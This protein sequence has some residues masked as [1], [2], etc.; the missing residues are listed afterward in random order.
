MKT[1]R[2]IF[3]V[4]GCGALARGLG[5]AE[6]SG[7]GLEPAPAENR[8][9]S[10]GD[11]S[12]EPGRVT[13]GEE[14]RAL[15]VGEQAHGKQDGNRVSDKSGLAGARKAKPKPYSGQER[16]KPAASNRDHS[17]GK[18]ADQTTLKNAAGTHQPA[19][20]Q[21]DGAPKEGP[22]KNMNSKPS[23]QPALP[24]SGQLPVLPVNPTHNRGPAPAIISGSTISS[25]AR[26]TAVINGTGLKH[27]P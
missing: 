6:T 13:E 5:A 8:S 27:K 7:Q 17:V 25:T 9:Q 21:S 23:S 26:N 19:L 1:L 22:T 20:R 16:G 12:L 18:G 14:N 10:I 15:R 3:V 24:S 11:H 2:F 4:V